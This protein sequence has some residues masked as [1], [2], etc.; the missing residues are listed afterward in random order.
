M[1]AYVLRS[2]GLSLADCGFLK[3]NAFFPPMLAAAHFTAVGFV[4]SEM[5]TTALAKMPVP[6]EKV[7]FFVIAFMPVLA[8]LCA[9]TA[10]M[11]LSAVAPEG[12]SS[13]KSREQKAPGAVAAKGLPKWIDRMQAAQYNTFEAAIC[14]ICSIFV[15]TSVEGGLSSTVLAKYMTLFFLCRVVYPFFYVFDLDLF[16]TQSWLTGLY[17]TVVVSFS[18]LFP[19]TMLPIF[20]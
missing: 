20:G 12:Y 16:R 17:I 9:I 8:I 10:L 15:A 18:A 4:K 14:L 6:T 1:L 11:A 2:M 5:A 3:L 7:P 19:E 13:Q